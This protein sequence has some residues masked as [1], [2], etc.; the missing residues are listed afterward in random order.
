MN[1]RTGIVTLLAL[2]LLA[3]FLRGTNFTDV[4]HQVQGVRADLLL[5]SLTM[6]ILTF[7]ARTIRW[8]ISSARLATL[9][10]ESCSGRR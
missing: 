5:L 4:W 6:V 2:G 1:L 7:F 3:W 8:L 9:A 10:F